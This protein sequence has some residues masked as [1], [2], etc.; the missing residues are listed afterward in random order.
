MRKEIALLAIFSQCASSVALACTTF[1]LDDGERR[2]IAKS[3]DYG[4]GHAQ[5]VVN[6]RGVRKTAVVLNPV[7]ETPAKWTS[8]YGSVTFNQAG[9]EFPYGGMNEAG[10][11]MEILWLDQTKYPEPGKKASTNESQWIQ[12][13][14]D[15]SSSVEEAIERAK[16]VDVNSLMA[17]VHYSVCDAKGA[18][19]VFEYL[20]GKLKISRQGK[21]GKALA[22]DPYTELPSGRAYEA[23][24]ISKNFSADVKDPVEYAFQGLEKVRQGN[25]T[26]WQI[27]YDVKEQ[28]IHFRTLA[29]PEIKTIDMTKL[30]FS[31]ETAPRVID[32]DHPK[33]G[34][35]TAQMAEYSV[36]AASA[37]AEKNTSLPW[38]LQKIAVYY[39]HLMTS[40]KAPTLEELE[41]ACEDERRPVQENA[42]IS[43]LLKVPLFFNAP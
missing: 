22:N 34:D 40:C 28:K 13:I 32:I 1:Q 15:T 9:R 23:K 6:K 25:W 5:V 18:C 42:A 29:E 16:E 33:G 4:H 43:E 41:E 36:S 8:L 24:E 26:K 7:K 30:D 20:D 10:L 35:V 38:Y 31:C 12:Y 11:N 21:D 37:N 19:A 2:Y 17:P 14:L 27:V 3:F 39:P